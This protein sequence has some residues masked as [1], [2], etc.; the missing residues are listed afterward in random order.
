MVGVDRRE[1][2][3]LELDWLRDILNVIVS[4]H[5]KFVEII[6]LVEGRTRP[7]SFFQSLEAE[8]RI[9]TCLS[10]VTRYWEYTQDPA[11]VTTGEGRDL[12][13]K[14]K[15]KLIKIEHRLNREFKILMTNLKTEFGYRQGKPRWI[16]FPPLVQKLYGILMQ[17][18]NHCLGEFP[19]VFGFGNFKLIRQK[20]I[21]SPPLEETVFDFE[22]S[23]ISSPQELIETWQQKYPYVEL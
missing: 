20:L 16:Q 5:E 15:L 4:L 23:S 13:V 6:K 7:F 8:R 14:E 12:N 3:E 2:S 18:L 11:E 19:H 10:I 17:T 9:T 22:L 21:T 1:E